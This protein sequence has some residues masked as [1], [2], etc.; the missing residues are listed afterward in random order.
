MCPVCFYSY[1]GKLSSTSICCRHI[2][3]Y[4]DMGQIHWSAPHIASI[5][6]V[7]IS[8]SNLI[9]FQLTEAVYIYLHG[10][11]LYM[12]L[13]SWDAHTHTPTNSSRQ[14]DNFIPDS[15]QHPPHD[16]LRALNTPEYTIHVF[17]TYEPTI[18][19][20]CAYYYYYYYG[21]VPLY[22]F[23]LYRAYQ[24]EEGFTKIP[25]WSPICTTKL[26]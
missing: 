18:L 17:A 2:C 19:C 23:V 26:I 16:E 5:F 11:Y 6:Q 4:I 15:I 12:H 24:W 1:F 25:V 13:E 7:C 22:V 3:T 8:I 10:V 21:Y 14:T 20:A 9:Y